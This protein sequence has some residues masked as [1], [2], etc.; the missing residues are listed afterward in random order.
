M[1]WQT[2]RATLLH[3]LRDLDDH[4]AWIQFDRLYGELILRY[5]RRRGLALTDA[6]DVRQIVLV[7]L[8]RALPGF[9]Y[10]RAR[11]RFRG[12]LGRTVR[13]A[14][15]RY[16]TR[17]NRTLEQLVPWEEALDPPAPGEHDEAWEREW[18]LHHLRAAMAA[19]RDRHDPASLEIFDAL[20]K[21]ET[22]AEIAE[23]RGITAAAVYKVKQRLRDRL[24]EQIDRQIAEEESF[25]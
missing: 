11:G 22:P 14:I 7:S 12:Y 16:N 18:A 3:R 13:N 21:G 2:T 15:F 20:L 9:T 17:P 25:E 23:A 19:L 6:E 10:D 8:A 24:R 4:D 5:C 1:E